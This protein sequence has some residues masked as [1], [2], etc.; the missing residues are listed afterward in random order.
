MKKLLVRKYEW[1]HTYPI[2]GPGEIQAILAEY[3]PHT[4]DA[5]ELVEEADYP[6]KG[7]A[8]ETGI[9]QIVNSGLS[10]RR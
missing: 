10:R 3:E 8:S 6:T 5:F 7:E 9:R 4:I 1:E 2:N